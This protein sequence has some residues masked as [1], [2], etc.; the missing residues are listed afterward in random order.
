MVCVKFLT[1]EDLLT[2]PQI[3]QSVDPYIRSRYASIHPADL[4]TALRAFK[5]NDETL[6][7]EE[8][9]QA[10]GG[11]TNLFKKVCDLQIVLPDDFWTPERFV[12]SPEM[13]FIHA[14]LPS[15]TP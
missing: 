11:N 15:R 2:P 5:R 3:S 1:E 10:C 13:H 14:F 7:R 8:V 4:Y 9:L 6:S 12:L